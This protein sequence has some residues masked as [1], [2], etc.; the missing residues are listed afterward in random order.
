MILYLN[1]N[2]A[3]LTQA[4][5]HQ[6]AL[7]QQT[8][9]TGVMWVRI[10]NL[11]IYDNVGSVSWNKRDC[12]RYFFFVFCSAV[13]AIPVF[14]HVLTNL[15][16]HI[17]TYNITTNHFPNNLY[18]LGFLKKYTIAFHSFECGCDHREYC[19]YYCLKSQSINMGLCRKWKCV[20]KCKM[21]WCSNLG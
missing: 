21:M 3:D 10:F 17:Y 15:S 2:L 8:E 4:I 5:D 20:L 18:F 7:P 1:L 16:L 9:S 13:W 6:A 11:F 19:D 12:Y 14:L